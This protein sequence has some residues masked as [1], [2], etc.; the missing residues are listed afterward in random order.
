MNPPTSTR[1]PARLETRAEVRAGQ[2]PP[3]DDPGATGLTGSTGTIGLPPGPVTSAELAAAVPDARDR[4]RYR[5]I[6]HG[7]YRR[8]DQVDD[9]A[10][11]TAALACA[12]PDGVLR[13]RSAALLWGD[14]TAP[15]DAPPEI[16]LPAT[17]RSTPGRVYRYGKLPREATTEVDGLRVTTPLRTCRDLAADLAVEDAVVAVERMCAV[18]PELVTLL[19]S[20]AEHP[21]GRGAARRFAEMVAL[22]DPCSGSADESRARVLLATAG[23]GRF[24]RGHEVRL[25]SRQLTLPLADPAA[26]CAVFVRTDGSPHAERPWDERAAD[27]LR[28]A[29]W[30]LVVVKGAALPTRATAPP[31]DGVASVLRSRW[32]ATAVL[33]PVDAVSAADPHGMWTA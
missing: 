23:V 11:R 22:V 24:S 31:G 13:G 12:W 1:V 7:M 4:R 19:G 33:E 29:G 30:A 5:R 21:A 25:R 20:A 6:W 17:R 16:W 26:R 10:L 2:F 28:L 18:R 27:E 8:E 9:L 15:A 3:A 14:D 32:P